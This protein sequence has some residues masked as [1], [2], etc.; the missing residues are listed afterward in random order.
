MLESAKRAKDSRQYRKKMQRLYKKWAHQV[1]G[2]A[3]APRA[4]GETIRNTGAP[5]GGLA[6]TQ[7]ADAE[8]C[9]RGASQTVEAKGELRGAVEQEVRKEKG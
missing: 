9:K 4:V 5:T 3:T 7:R 8:K 6:T 2:F 1:E